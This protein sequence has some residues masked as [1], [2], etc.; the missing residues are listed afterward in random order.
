[1][2]I[3]GNTY[4]RILTVI[5]VLQGVAFYAIAMRPERIPPVGPLDLFPNEFAGWVVM[6]E[7][8]I[9]P[10]VQDILKADD[11][12]SREYV[13]TKGPEG[14]YLFI[15]FF[16]TQREGQAPHSPKNCLPGA[17]FEPIEAF[18]I[19]VKFP[20]RDEPTKINRYLTARGDEKSITLYWY[21]S[22]SRIIAD[23]FAA[24]FWLI[25]DSMRYHRSDTALV[26]VVVP[27]RNNDAARATDTAVAF[28][29][30]MFPALMRQL[31]M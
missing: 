27:V 30:A 12:L 4:V 23:E 28:A 18:P 11:L 31:P 6:R 2:N 26:K 16:K 10:E 15:A 7:V 9:E 1:L 5:L 24:K 8:K 19:E 3:L 13:N 25:A 21:Q 20:G 22:H 17:G 14:A 29:Q